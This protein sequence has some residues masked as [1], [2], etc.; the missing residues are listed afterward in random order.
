MKKGKIFV[1]IASYRDPELIP[2]IEDMIKKA[3]KPKNLVFGI[4][5]QYDSSEPIDMFDNNPQ[6]RV[7]K[8]HYSESEGLGWA[9]HITNTLYNDEEF[10]VILR[11]I[12][13]GSILY[14][15][16]D[17]GYINSYEDDKTEETFFL[18]E[19]GRKMLNKKGT[20]R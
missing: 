2:T 11:E 1:Q 19:E 5:W 14:E 17:K 6:F 8:H 18:T 7:S 3:K 16:K 12:V 4:C 15:L 13:S 10:D 9:R 20:L